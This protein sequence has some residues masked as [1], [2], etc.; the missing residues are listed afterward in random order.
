MASITMIGMKTPIDPAKLRKARKARGLTQTQLAEKAGK[1]LTVHAVSA[2]ERG[3][4]I[5]VTRDE[6]NALAETLGI[7]LNDLETPAAESFLT[8]AGLHL[9]PMRLR[10]ARKA[11]GL[12]QEQLAT[13]S[14]FNQSSLSKLETG[15]AGI[16]LAG[17]QALAEALNVAVNYLLGG[18]EETR[19][20][21]DPLA[22][23]RDSYEMPAG[24]RE[25]ANASTLVEELR[26][27]PDEWRAL[28][29]LAAGW[30]NAHLVRRDGWVQILLLLRSATPD[31]DTRANE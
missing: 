12:T 16:S 10:I 17:V 8:P 14:G 4:K 25:L 15:S 11:V 23:I 19:E 5:D 31:P 9:D 29:S 20:E 6:L 26:I 21:S 27:E 3:R 18:A 2:L 13:R 1:G 28:A 24:L 7:T 22:T 30:R